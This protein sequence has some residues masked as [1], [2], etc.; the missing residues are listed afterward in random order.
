[1]SHS[2]AGAESAA[3]PKPV[4]PTSSSSRAPAASGAGT[5]RRRSVRISGESTTFASA[6]NTTGRTIAREK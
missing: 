6:A 4:A 2:A 5:P 3:T 1:L